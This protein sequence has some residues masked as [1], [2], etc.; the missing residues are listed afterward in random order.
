M[1]PRQAY[2]RGRQFLAIVQIGEGI[3]PV[4]PVEDGARRAMSGEERARASLAARQ[5][6]LDRGAQSGGP[7]PEERLQA[8]R[9]LGDRDRRSGNRDRGAKARNEIARREWRV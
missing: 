8:S 2:L 6:G 1:S 3:R 5:S 4:F 7:K 9:P